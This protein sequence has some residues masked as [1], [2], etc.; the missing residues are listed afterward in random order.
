MKQGN[1]IPKVIHESKIKLDGL[2]IR[3]CVLDN[4]QRVIPEEDFNKFLNFLGTS[5]EDVYELMKIAGIRK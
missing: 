2:E 3:V 4:G 1:N 5:K